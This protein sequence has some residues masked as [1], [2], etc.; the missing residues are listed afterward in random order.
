M[1]IDRLFETEI[2]EQRA[3]VAVYLRDAADRLEAGELEFH[4]DEETVVLDVPEQVTLEVTVEQD[5]DAPDAGDVRRVR[6]ELHLE[7]TA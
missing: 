7:K 5:D 4:D 2:R 6:F 1:G 3:G